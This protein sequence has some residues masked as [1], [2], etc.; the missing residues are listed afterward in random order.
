MLRSRTTLIINTDMPPF[1]ILKPS[2]K[3][4]GAG[5]G[6]VKTPAPDAAK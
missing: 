4:P 5:N 2:F 3:F 6:S 1:D